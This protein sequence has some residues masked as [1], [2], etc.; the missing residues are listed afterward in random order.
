[1]IKPRSTDKDDNDNGDDDDDEQQ[2]LYQEQLETVLQTETEE[3][4]IF[5]K[6]ITVNGNFEEML[7]NWE[8]ETWKNRSTTAVQKRIRE[9]ESNTI[10]SKKKKILN[11]L[12]R[13]TFTH[14]SVNMI[15][16]PK[17]QLMR[18][19]TNATERMPTQKT[20]LK[21]PNDAV[22]KQTAPQTKSR[23][24]EDN[25]QTDRTNLSQARNIVVCSS[26]SQASSNTKLLETEKTNKS[27]IGSLLKFLEG[28]K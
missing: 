2:Q 17:N 18:K 27:S 3:D 10:S 4:R 20:I 21:Q 6:A 23:T 16:T 22:M 28:S 19:Q 5:D 11:S 25:R 13:Q 7:E 15:A 12:A 24:S 26:A 1:V 14:N 9:C 8:S